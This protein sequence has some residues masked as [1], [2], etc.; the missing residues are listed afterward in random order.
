MLTRLI[1]PLS[2][3]ERISWRLRNVIAKASGEN[4]SLVFNEAVR[5]DL[6]P[7]DVG[8]QSIILNGFVELDLTKRLKRLA[9]QGGLFVDVGANYGYF[10]CL[11]AA[12]QRTNQSVAFE[13]SPLNIPAIQRNITKNTLDRQIKLEPVALGREVGTL[14]FTLENAEGQTGWGGFT[15]ENSSTAVAVNVTTLDKYAQANGIEKIDVLKIDVE[16]ADTWVLLG[17]G[18]LIRQKR[19]KHIFFEMNKSRMNLLNIAP[20]EAEKFLTEHGYVVKR[21]SDEEYYAHVA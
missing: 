21:M 5:L 17:A 9:E 3:R 12:E 18:D 19:I 16:G 7:K 4:V 13:A 6:S 11:W 15:L 10:A 14:N 20:D 1:Y 2:L 8:H